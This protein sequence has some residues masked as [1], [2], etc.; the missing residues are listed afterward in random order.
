[1]TTS[2]SPRPRRFDGAPGAARWDL[3]VIGGGLLG[4][5]A[6]L[7]AARGGMR[8]VLIERGRLCREASGVNAGTL[9]MH[10]TRRALIPYAL[11]GHA[12]WADASSWLGHDVGVRV[13]DG[14]S[15]AFTEREE[16]LLTERAAKRR[17]AGAPIEIVSAARAR[18]IEPGLSDQVRA[19]AYCPIDGFANAYLTGLAFRR[20]L[21]EAGVDLLEDVRATGVEPRGDGW[22][23]ACG[24]GVGPI[25]ATRIVLAGGAWTGQMLAWLGV[26]LP[27]KALINQLAVTERTPPVMRS[28]IGIA[29]GLLSLKQYPHG[30]TVIGGGW[31]GVGAPDAGRGAPSIASLVGNLRLACHAIPALRTARLARSWT[32]YEAETPDALPIVGPIDGHPGAYVCASVHSGYTSGHYLARLLAEEILGRQPERP[33]FPISRFSA[34]GGDVSSEFR[35]GARR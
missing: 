30:T 26:A 20:A 9:T 1:M 24:A 35:E 10:M 28:V 3:A 34:L 27:I 18:E 6:A 23:V 32:G 16:A 5:T 15:L 31:Q 17:E 21:R 19:A 4:A 7:F 14:L 33:L 13:C 11:E 29:S 25:D 2:P 22:R 12:M 8:V